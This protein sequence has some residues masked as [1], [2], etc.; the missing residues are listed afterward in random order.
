MKSAEQDR[1]EHGGEV[2]QPEL[3]PEPAAIQIPNQP[4]RLLDTAQ[5]AEYLRVQVQTLAN[6]R[7]EG[8]GPAFVRVGRLIRY[9]LSAIDAWLAKQS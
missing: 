1:G 2:P 6:W 8:R 9:R 5:A 3:A 7:V 4:H